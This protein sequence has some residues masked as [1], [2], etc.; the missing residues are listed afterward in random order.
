[1]RVTKTQ[2]QPVHD[3]EDGSVRGYQSTGK[4]YQIILQKKT[5]LQPA[6]AT[7]IDNSPFSP[8]DLRTLTEAGSIEVLRDK[9]AETFNEWDEKTDRI[10]EVLEEL[11]AVGCF[12]KLQSE[13]QVTVSDASAGE[14][15]ANLLESELHAVSGAEPNISPEQV[16]KVL[17]DAGTPVDR[18]RSVTQ[19]LSES[20]SPT[21]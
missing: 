17:S 20:T 11:C 8:V 6:Y 4:R 12:I 16:A 15:V 5:G 18:I 21:K 7:L 13:H 3:D 9:L 19:K 2:W 14:L 1:M 10:N